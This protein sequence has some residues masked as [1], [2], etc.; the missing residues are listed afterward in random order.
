MKR[1]IFSLVP[2]GLKRR[3]AMSLFRSLAVKIETEKDHL[4]KYKLNVSQIES[5]E[6]LINRQTLLERM[7]KNAV[8]AELGVDYG[9]FSELILETANPLRLHLIDLWGSGRYGKNKKDHVFKKFEKEINE[10]Q[11]EINL[12][13]STEVVNT[14]DHKYFDW[15]YIDTDHSYKTTIQELELYAP[16]M[17]PEGII[18]GHDFTTGNWDG[19][20][21]YGVIEAVYE[22][23]SKHKWQFLYLTMDMDHNPSFAIRKMK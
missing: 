10:G 12:G 5:A 18:A 23:C 6:L 9:G 19:A 8:V 16:K 3:I 14:F 7:P 22:F 15:I 20:V 13:Y 1:L 17:K 2:D 21:R 4:E 11:V